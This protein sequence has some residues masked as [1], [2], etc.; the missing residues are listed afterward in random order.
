MKAPKRSQNPFV[1]QQIR[2]SVQDILLG[3]CPD[4][5]IADVVPLF[6]ASPLIAEFL[7]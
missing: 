1:E 7:F 6:L 5:G 3:N 2:L 4:A